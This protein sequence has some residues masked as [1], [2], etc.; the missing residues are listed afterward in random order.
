[1]DRIF[2]PEFKNLEKNNEIKLD[3]LKVAVLYGANGTGKTD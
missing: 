2:E 3:K 1:M